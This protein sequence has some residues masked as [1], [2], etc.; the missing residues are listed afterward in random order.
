MYYC[1]DYIEKVYESDEKNRKHYH[2]L[3]TAGHNSKF[4]IYFYEMSKKINGKISQQVY[5]KNIFKL[6]AKL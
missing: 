6:L 2:C 5:M 4:D 1:P 3:A